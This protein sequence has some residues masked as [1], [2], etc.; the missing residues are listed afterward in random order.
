ME[1]NTSILFAFTLLVGLVSGVVF[2]VGYMEKDSANMLLRAEEQRIY[3]VN[4][5]LASF[6]IT[7]QDQTLS[8]EFQKWYDEALLRGTA[9]EIVGLIVLSVGAIVVAY[10]FHKWSK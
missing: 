4:E 7:D 1:E 3:D 8:I 6:N 9:E 5:I 2:A 10:G